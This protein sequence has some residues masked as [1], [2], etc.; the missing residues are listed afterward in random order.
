MKIYAE[1]YGC[2]ANVA[3]SEIALGLLREEG[4]EIV[5]NPRDADAIVIFT[6]VVKKPTSDRMLYRISSLAGYGKRLIVAG[7]IVPG[8]P[9]NVVRIAPDA[10]MLHPRAIT[11]IRDAVELGKSFPEECDEVKLCMP[12][13]R[14]SPLIAIIPVSEGCS[15][16]LC[17][18][19]IVTRTRGSFKSYSMELIECEVRRH[20]EEGAREIWLT[21]QDMGSYGIESGKSRVAELVKRIAEIDGTFFIRVGMMNPLYIYPVL[22]DLVE[23]YKAPRVFKFLHL[24]LQS[25][26]NKVL[27]D[28]RR[29]YDVRVF[30]K[31]VE[32]TRSEIP[33]LTLSTDIIVGYPT[34]D[35]SDFEETV[36]LVE[37]VKPDVIN[38]S[39][40]FPRPGTS[41]ERLRPLDPKIVKKRS[42][43]LSEVAREIAL[44]NN[45]K[46]IGWRGVALV[47]EVGERGEAI[48]K[49]ASYRSIVL[50]GSGRELFGKLVEVEVE[51]AR[52]YCLLAE[53]KR[54]LEPVEI[55]ELTSA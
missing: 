36:K 48:A 22:R 30:K 49:N 40:F 27:R 10:V 38:I 42:K 35:E 31:I 9:E 26:S 5:S 41:A 33:N 23:A 37:D 4:H 25:G 51:D 34:E 6:C 8:E 32:S 15:W 13:L 50:R 53:A 54:I 11:R 17:S 24:P 1:T 21:S 43:L 20:L 12:R 14:R 47:D 46:W 44:R 18:F 2:A 16:N 29:G 19:C 52:P 39:R 45:E 3:D 28:M 55:A 7:C